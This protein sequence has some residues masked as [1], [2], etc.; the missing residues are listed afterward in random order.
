M[1][2]IFFSIQLLLIS[3]LVNAEG[4]RIA[5]K[6]EGLS[7]TKI[8]IAH[9][10]DSNI[11]LNDSTLLDQNGNGI[12]SG[13]SLLNQGLYV[14][15]YNKD[16]YFDFLVGEDQNFEIYSNLNELQKSIKI[17][18][19]TESEDFRNYQNFIMQQIALRNEYSEKTKNSDS[20]IS[21][22]A[23]KSLEKLEKEMSN[24]LKKEITR[25]KGTM[26][27]LFLKTSNAPEIPEP[28]FEK[29]NP[30]Y[31]SL[32]WFYYYNFKRDHFLDNI[33]FND[34]RILNSPL[35]KSNLDVYFNKILIQYPDSIIPQAIKTI[36]KSES[37][38]K[39]YQ[40]VTQYL[41]NNSIQSK[42]M[43]MDAVFVAVSDEVYM[44]GKAT[45]ADSTT[46]AK[47]KEETY[48]IRN[49]I[50]GKTAPELV[51]ENIDGE[52][53]SLHQSI[54]KYT[55][56]VFYEYDC[57]HCK[58]EVPELYNDVYQKYLG[59]NIEVYAVCMNDDSVKWKEFVETNQL[60]GWHHLWDPKHR[61]LFRFK[62]NVKTT[63][64]I[65][66]LDKDKKIIAKKIDNI[67]LT[68]LLDA[69]LKKK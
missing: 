21:N 55:I 68:K 3:F 24:Y 44:K 43:G 36:R 7:N 35:V 45:W 1:K 37:N 59:D 14:M 22:E 51:M 46:L 25:T 34:E 60:A 13:D 31:D 20:I 11:Y 64:M 2:K 18:G 53:E 65:Y 4:Y 39:M 33:D 57:G 27:S 58:K 48:L 28:P 19:S 10:F 54:G 47:V 6:W 40:Y 38:K 49:N 69:L 52:M 9:Y 26:Y 41:L 30:K 56:L 15:Y 12:F 29:N 23:Y 63:P 32:A 16:T 62:Y 66:L 42:I 8:F 61:T 67:T 17:S 50:I 5:V